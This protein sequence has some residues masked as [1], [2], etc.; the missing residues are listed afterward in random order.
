MLKIAPNLFWIPFWLFGSCKNKSPKYMLTIAD[1]N[2]SN[3]IDFKFLKSFKN[4]R[5]NSQ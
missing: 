3:L 2:A 1:S 4:S 5:F